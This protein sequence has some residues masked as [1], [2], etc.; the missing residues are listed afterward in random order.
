MT[1]G[2]YKLHVKTV[3]GPEK[4]DIA[5]LLALFV[6]ALV[7]RI[8]F[9]ISVKKDKTREKRRGGNMENFLIAIFF[10]WLGLLAGTI[11]TWRYE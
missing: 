6:K 11:I 4:E 7:S 10:F 5:V 3:T 2:I 8:S 1:L 9:V